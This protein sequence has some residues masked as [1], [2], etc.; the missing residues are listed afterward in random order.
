MYA[1]VNQ[2][3]VKFRLQISSDELLLI[4]HLCSNQKPYNF[5]PQQD[6]LLPVPVNLWY[7][8][9]SVAMYIQCIGTQWRLDSLLFDDLSGH[10]Y[11]FTFLMF[12]IFFSYY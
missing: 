1:C 8:M 7:F 9:A 10:S 4:T 2:V 11:L 6:V 3:A 5:W 12:L